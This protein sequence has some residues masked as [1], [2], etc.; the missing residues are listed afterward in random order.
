LRASADEIIRANHLAYIGS[1]A[2]I[3]SGVG[4]FAPLIQAV[5]ECYRAHAAGDVVLPK[6]EYLKYEDRPS[7]DRIIPLLGYL[8]G[9]FQVSGL[10]QICSSTANVRHGRPR[11]SGLII[12]NDPDTN[13]PFGVLEASLISAARTAAVSGLALRLF[14]APSMAQVAILGCGQLARTHLQMLVDVFGPDRFQFTVYDLVRERADALVLLA[15]ELGAQAKVANHAQGAVETADIVLPA[16]TAEA[17][18]IEYEWLKPTCI[19]CAVS[20]LDAKLDI[21]RNAD[22]IVVDDL[23]QCLNEGR[24]LDL[25]RR[26]GELPSDRIV[27]IGTA[28]KSSVGAPWLSGLLVFNPMGTVITDLAVAKTLFDRA[29]ANG[30]FVSL[31]I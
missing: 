30:D 8:G 21:Y 7:Y 5:E 29:L 13:R 23:T 11:A 20:L 17:A 1:A 26:A 12:L 31:E 3:R 6:S 4:Q 28:L 27:E 24:P 16:T 15:A 22:L 10:K 25:L 19:Y 14:L 2:V 9:A 18:Y